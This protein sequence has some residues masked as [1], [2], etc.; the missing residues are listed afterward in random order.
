MRVIGKI[1]SI[2]LSEYFLYFPTSFPLLISDMKTTITSCVFTFFVVPFVVVTSFYL[3]NGISHVY[4]TLI[5]WATCAFRYEYEL[6]NAFQCLAKFNISYHFTN[7][8]FVNK[9]FRQW[10]LYF[11]EKLFRKLQISNLPPM[12]NAFRT[13]FRIVL[14]AEERSSV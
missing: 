7:L 9:Y 2:K 3:H 11:S 5:S 4:A 12:K 8:S 10:K 1:L 13:W 6:C 14:V